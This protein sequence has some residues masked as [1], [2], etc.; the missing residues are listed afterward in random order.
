MAL[1]QGLPLVVGCDLS[2]G[3]LI[4]HPVTWLIFCVFI[5]KGDW[6]TWSWVLALP[7]N[8]YF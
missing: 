5:L 1:L 2:E 6:S 3:L 8:L 4:A 7:K